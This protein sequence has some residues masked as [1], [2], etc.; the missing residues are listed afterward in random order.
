LHTNPS[1]LLTIVI[2]IEESFSFSP[3]LLIYFFYIILKRRGIE[4]EILVDGAFYITPFKTVMLPHGGFF[5]CAYHFL[6]L[7]I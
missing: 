1:I 3:I 2:L 6:A 7:F 4:K 5:I